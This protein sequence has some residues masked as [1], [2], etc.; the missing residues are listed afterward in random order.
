MVHLRKSKKGNRGFT[1]I[2]LLVVMAIIVIIA[3]IAIPKYLAAIESGKESAAVGNL[4]TLFTA[5][6]MF[7]TR[8]PTTGFAPT[9]AALGDNGTEPCVQ[10]VAS[11]C[12]IDQVLSSGVSGNYTFTYTPSTGT[13]GSNVGFTV[14]AVPANTGWIYYFMD[15]SGVIRQSTGSA[16]TVASA[17][18]GS[19]SAAAHP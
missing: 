17:P 4:K 11:A 1:L 8:Y 2:E 14:T 9:L 19:G 3:A 10:S 18:I 6:N 7:S 13:D 16:A 15:E 12:L 5:D